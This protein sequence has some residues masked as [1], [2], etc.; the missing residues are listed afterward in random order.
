MLFSLFYIT[1]TIILREILGSTLAASRGE[2]KSGWESKGEVDEKRFAS[3]G[4]FHFRCGKRDRCN[5]IHGVGKNSCQVNRK[6]RS[7]TVAEGE[8]TT[9][10]KRAAIKQTSVSQGNLIEKHLRHQRFRPFVCRRKA[11]ISLTIKTASVSSV[12]FD[13]FYRECKNETIPPPNMGEYNNLEE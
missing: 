11:N 1:G 4:G 13:P 3:P 12:I 2:C 10:V 7:T 6:F 8:G 9:L 5:N